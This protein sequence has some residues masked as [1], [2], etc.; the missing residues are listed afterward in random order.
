MTHFVYFIGGP[1][2]L[3]KRAFP[4][5]SPRGRYMRFPVYPD[6]ATFYG[7]DEDVPMDEHGRI[8]VDVREVEYE[9]HPVYS[10]RGPVAWIGV[11][12]A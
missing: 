8:K 9:L 4:G 3:T 7:P 5:E 6:K 11:V 12:R 1:L 2:D 10:A